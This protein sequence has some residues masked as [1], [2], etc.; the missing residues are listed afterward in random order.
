MTRDAPTTVRVELGARAY[1]ILVGPGLLGRAGALIGALLTRPRVH[2]VT[3]ATVP[4][5]YGAAFDAAL[6]LEGIGVHRV[7]VPAGETSKSLESL[8]RVLDALLAAGCERSDLIVALGGGVI[9]DLAGFAAAVLRRGV[10][11]VQVPTTLLAQVDSAVGGK[12]AIDSRH[13]KNLIGAFHQPSLVIADTDVL[14]TL[15]PRELRA[16]YAEVVKYGLLGDEPFFAWLEAHG[17]A[18]LTGDAQARRHA[19]AV[20]CAAKA[21]IVAADEREGLAVV[22]MQLRDVD[23]KHPAANP[24][25]VFAAPRRPAPGSSPRAARGR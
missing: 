14:T 2:V 5:V 12:T 10:A 4:A 23:L 9:G 25:P 6:A 19:I 1:D 11:Y 7:V 8:G 24:R 18:V 3:E 16:G 15:P 13:G 22:L 17:Q 21:R 20:A